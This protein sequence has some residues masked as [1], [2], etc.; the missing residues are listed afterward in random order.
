[1]SSL[2]QG[3]L[4][5]TALLFSKTLERINAFHFKEVRMIEEPKPYTKRVFSGLMTLLATIDMR[6][7]LNSNNEF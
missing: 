2:T 4:S 7:P 6:V 5:A 3:D 1:M